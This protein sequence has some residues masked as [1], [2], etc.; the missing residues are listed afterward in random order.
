MRKFDFTLIELLTV[1]AIIAILMALI[2]PSLGKAKR[3]AKQISCANNLKQISLAIS[4]YETDFDGY[5]PPAYTSTTVN[6]AIML[7]RSDYINCWKLYDGA[8]WCPEKDLVA[9]YNRYGMNKFTLPDG[10]S[11]KFV[12]ISNPSITVNLADNGNNSTVD[13]LWH[14]YPNSM[15]VHPRHLAGANYLFY[16]MHVS[17]SRTNPADTTKFKWA[18]P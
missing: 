6:W 15:A 1:I 12:R 3:K 2:F 9:A 8:N 13:G 11:I 5:P 18:L 10:G 14:V 16:D 7:L 17:C 4:S